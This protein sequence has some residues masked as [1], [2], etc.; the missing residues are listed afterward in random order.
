MRF[1]VLARPGAAGGVRPIP[2]PKSSGEYVSASSTSSYAHS[3]AS[4]N[5]TLSS[6]TDG[7]S[8]S[9]ALFEQHREHPG[10][11][12]FAAQLKKLY[13]FISNLEAKLMKEDSVEAADEGRVS[14]KR[15]NDATNV[16]SEE[17]EKE[18]WR[19]KIADRKQYVFLDCSN[20]AQYSFASQTR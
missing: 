3:V 2:T 18:R 5:F 8:A 16:E 20:V 10:T 4:S 1:S 9:S 7:S 12:A 17:A 13:R 15:A 14:L 6:T 11:S 19:K